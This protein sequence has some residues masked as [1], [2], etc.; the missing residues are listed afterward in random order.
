[1]FVD[2]WCISDSSEDAPA[3]PRPV[4]TPRFAIFVLCRLSLNPFADIC[5]AIR[6][7]NVF[8]FA[9]SQ[10]THRFAIHEFHLVQIQN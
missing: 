10:K 9:T 8:R 6:E 5:R 7:L 4:K 2:V 3:E 1:M